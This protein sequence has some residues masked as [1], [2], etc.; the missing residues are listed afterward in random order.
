[1]GINHHINADTCQGYD[2]G[3]KC[4]ALRSHSPY[5]P[6]PCE[7]GPVIPRAQRGIKLGTHGYRVNAIRTSHASTC[8]LGG[9]DMGISSVIA[10]DY[11]C[12][13]LGINLR[14]KCLIRSHT[15]KTLSSA[16]GLKI[17]SALNPLFADSLV[18]QRR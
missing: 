4:R 6:S 2:A 1:M 12:I 10:V 3:E 13:T 16:C 15:G 7:H 18:A 17:I 14:M 5:S 9:D 8:G 11:R